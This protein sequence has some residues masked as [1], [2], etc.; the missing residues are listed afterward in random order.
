MAYI[1]HLSGWLPERVLTNEDLHRENPSWDTDRI[2]GKTGILSRRI[3]ADRETA[4]DLAFAAAQHLFAGTSL[5]PGDI[6]YL[7]FCTQSPDYHLPAS[8]CVL[9]DRL[10]LPVDCGAI[11]INQGCSAYTYGLQLANA[12][13]ESQSAGKVLLLTGETYSK[14]IHPRDRSVRVL[15]GDA[16]TATVIGA[17]PPGARIVASVVGTDGSGYKNLII[18]S[19]GARQRPGSSA[20]PEVEDENGNVRSPANLFM[21]GQE[22]FNFTL[23][24]VPRLVDALLKKADTAV[25]DVDAFIFHQANAFMNEHLRVKIKLPKQKV[26]FVSADVGNTVSNTIPLALTRVGHQF[27]CGN[28]IAL[29]GFGVGYSWGACL[30]EWGN[31]EIAEPICGAEALSPGS[32]TDLE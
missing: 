11:D 30:L 3:A 2:A 25:D 26:P 18:P 19:G 23:R 32:G 24:R 5:G 8:A 1:T 14:Y 21:D 13:V 22:L 20:L 28:K 15:F 4:S 17:D 9:Q 10:K 12:L 6:D 27:S 31:V 16:A 7:L 29:I